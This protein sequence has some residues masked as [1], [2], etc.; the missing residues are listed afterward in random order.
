[1]RILYGGPRAGLVAVLTV[2]CNAVIQV[3][4]VL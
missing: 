4:A 3:A 1:M 2:A